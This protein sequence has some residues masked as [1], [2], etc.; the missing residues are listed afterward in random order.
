[1]SGVRGRAEIG[2]E[3]EF[4]ADSPLST[5]LDVGVD[6]M[7]LRSR[8]EPKPRVGC[9]TRGATRCP[10]VNAFLGSFIEMHDSYT[11]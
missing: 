4:S 1:M 11:F 7:T 5:E 10:Y 3:R 8:P 9:L 6:L 2:G